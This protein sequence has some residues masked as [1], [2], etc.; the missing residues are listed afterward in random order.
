MSN[1]DFPGESER[2][3]D[4]PVI[5]PEPPRIVNLPTSFDMSEFFSEAVEPQPFASEDPETEAPAAVEPPASTAS[6][7]EFP[8]HAPEPPTVRSLPPMSDG[9]VTLLDILENQGG[10]TWRETVALVHQLC[11]RLKEQSTLVPILL[12]PRNILIT[13]TGDVELLPGQIG[14]DPLVMQIGRLL[15]TMLRGKAAPP[16]LRLLVAQATFEVPIFETIEDIDRALVKIERLDESDSDADRYPVPDTIQVPAT[17][18]S[19]DLP[20]A[21]S[22]P[23][24]PPAQPRRFRH[25]VAPLAMMVSSNSARLVA[26]VLIVI[27][28]AILMINPPVYIWQNPPRQISSTQGTFGVA[29]PSAAE[30]V[31]AAAP[32]AQPARPA[33]RD[34][35]VPA[36][37]PEASRPALA[38]TV[39]SRTPDRNNAIIEPRSERSS[40][41]TRAAETAVPTPT[42]TPRDSARRASELVAQGQTAQAAMVFDSLLMAN[43]LYEPKATDLTPESMS[44]FRASQRVLLPSLA[45][46]GY[47]RAKAALAAGDVDRALAAVKETAAIL[48]RPAA[49]ATAE[50]KLRLQELGEQATFAKVTAD[51]VIYSAADAGV[52]PPRPISRQFP[53]ATPN[54]VPPHRIGT[55]EMIIGKDGTV[56]FVKLHTPLN[57]YHERMIVSAAKAWQ[58]RPAMR[59]GKAVKYRLT[60]QINL[61]ENGT[62]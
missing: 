28:I 18:A 12:D 42:V 41:A 51:E 53:A 37:N 60:V 40:R 54:G 4:A 25:R 24:R 8:T 20:T 56:E 30:A 26:G 55:L 11:L 17:L 57:R 13:P 58:Y 62:Y 19:G 43:P 38:P 45:M 15:Q 16:E 46:R 10:M 3:P 61:P 21:Q 5:R 1:F 49:N 9:V 29:T 50:Q 6:V 48:E 32:A 27:A 7:L 31:Q 39:T 47:D 44:A 35:E 22:R 33:T 36:A 34:A 23:L 59:A 2:D 52:V 14:G